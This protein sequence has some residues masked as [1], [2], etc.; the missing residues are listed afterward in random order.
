M[1]SIFLDFHVLLQ[2]LFGG[3]NNYLKSQ[4]STRFNLCFFSGFNISI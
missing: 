4:T 3:I 1:K 2:H